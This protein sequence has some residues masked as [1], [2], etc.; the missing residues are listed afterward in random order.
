M[1]QPDSMA[2]QEHNLSYQGT[3]MYHQTQTPSM[4]MA[5]IILML[6]LESGKVD[7]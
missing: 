2:Y 4:T 3:D 1:G 5:L 7:L 6:A